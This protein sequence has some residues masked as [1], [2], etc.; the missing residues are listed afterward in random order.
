MSV[1]LT[2]AGVC[3]LGDDTYGRVTADDLVCVVKD[4]AEAD[5]KLEPKPREVVE[6]KHILSAY[7]RLLRVENMQKPFGFSDQLKTPVPRQEYTPFEI[8]SCGLQ[9]MVALGSGRI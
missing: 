8:D 5:A 9:I 2:I 1:G 7:T 3:A 4:I 6:G